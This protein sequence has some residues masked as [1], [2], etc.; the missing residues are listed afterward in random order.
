MAHSWTTPADVVDKL[1]RRH[2]RGEFLTSYAE[3]RPWEP[4]AVNLRGPSA[5]DLAGRFAEVQEWVEHWRDRPRGLRVET[6]AVGGRVVGV[7][8]IPRR[9]WVDSAEQLW[10]L[11]G[12]ARDVQRFGALLDTAKERAPRVAEWM[13][14]KPLQV[15]RYAH[16]WTSL[17]DTVLWIEAHA[18][19][20][21]YLR[22]VDVPGVDTKF[23]EGHRAI[24]AAL[25]DRQ[26]APER[27]DAG[28]PPSDFA[29]RYRLRGKPAFVRFRRLG[30]TTGFSE[31]SVRVDEWATMPPQERTVFVVENEVTYLAFPRVPDAI[32]I[33]GSG[34]AVS[35]L[36]PLPWLADRELIYWGDIDTHGFVI[37]DRLRRV[38]GDTRSMLMD[39]ATLLAH[40]RQWVIEDS[41]TD[42]ALPLL[43]PEEAAL[44]TDLV[45]NALGSAIRLEQER[46]SFAAVERAVRE[47]EFASQGGR[48]DSVRAR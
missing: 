45:E 22:Q 9:A 7:N 1:R 24:L 5:R 31:L 14:A 15:L 38:F 6:A 3:G 2:E 19:P 33:F 32:V 42:A 4:L 17:L 8:E 47:A 46:V 18:S 34:Y 26:L 41:P 40:E 30:G 36:E 21:M 10:S 35:R 43:T 48:P 39:R 25:L 28:C 27:I 12:V 20:E 37:L 29:G 13:A 23:I 44:Y 16:V 11:L